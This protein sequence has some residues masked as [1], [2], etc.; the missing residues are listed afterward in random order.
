MTV[1]VSQKWW[2]Y[3]NSYYDYP[4]F[5]SDVM[6]IDVNVLHPKD[7]F[8]TLVYMLCVCEYTPPAGQRTGSDT[9]SRGIEAHADWLLLHSV[10]FFHP[11][12][13][14]LNERFAVACLKFKYIV[15][16]WHINLII[17]I[18]PHGLDSRRKTILTTWRK[19]SMRQRENKP[20]VWETNV[21]H[22]VSLLVMQLHTVLSCASNMAVQVVST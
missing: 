18:I 13:A 19:N 21:L 16:Q 11:F 17:L 1:Y 2:E 5:H 4:L 6:S 8:C 12:R 15:C 14:K 20:F 10:L 7:W 9:E 3:Q 22:A